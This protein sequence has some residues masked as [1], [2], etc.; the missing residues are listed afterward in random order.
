MLHPL[1]F[2]MLFIKEMEIALFFSLAAS[3][4]ALADTKQF[5][6]SGWIAAWAFLFLVAASGRF[7]LFF[8]PAAAPFAIQSFIF[9][10][11]AASFLYF[12]YRLPRR[13]FSPEAWGF[14]ALESAIFF[15]FFL[16]H[17]HPIYDVDSLTYYLSALQWHWQRFSLPEPWRFSENFYICYRMLGFEEFLAVAG[18]PGNLAFFMGLQQGLFKILTYFTLASCFPRGFRLGRWVLLFLLCKEEHFFFSGLSRW[19]NFTPSFI[20]LTAFAAYCTWRAIR[21][22]ATSFW[23]AIALIIALAAV[24]YHGL[25]VGA[26]L[27]LLLGLYVVHKRALPRFPQSA[28]ERWILSSALL[29]FLLHFA[30]VYGMNWWETGTPFYPLNFGPFRDPRFT[31]GMA[32]LSAEVPAGS[33]WRAFLQPYYTVRVFPANLAM[34]ITTYVMFFYFAAWAILKWKA[35]AFAGLK[36]F[37]K[38][39]AGIFPLSERSVSFIAFAAMATWVWAAYGDQIA[40]NET[41]YPCYIFG[42]S[43]LLVIT[44]LFSWRPRKWRIFYLPTLP[45]LPLGYI[46]FIYLA[47]TTDS[48]VTKVALDDRPN[49]QSIR[50]FLKAGAPPPLGLNPPY[51]QFFDAWSKEN[52]ADILSCLKSKQMRDQDFI[53][54][55][56]QMNWPAH[57]IG[58]SVARADQFSGFSAE[59]LPYFKFALVPRAYLKKDPRISPAATE[60]LRRGNMQPPLCGSSEMALVRI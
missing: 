37:L 52:L 6:V 7:L 33:F 34:R 46:I 60:I 12:A 56:P 18:L 47:A 55:S 24:K 1:P 13:R 49:W 5:R 10:A 39:K 17:F 30:S 9:A 53:A 14:L 11:A 35:S 50:G 3:S 27:A 25:P 8:L 44:F 38:R 48:R 51:E 59:F 42:L 2:Q 29:I 20:C 21:G 19:V 54:I 15:Y 40:H 57:L 22:H 28:I 41:R 32:A 4:F 26:A 58:P 16:R 45:A 43:A 36:K 31:N 23:Q